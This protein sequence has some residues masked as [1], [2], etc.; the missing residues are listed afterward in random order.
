MLQVSAPIGAPVEI[1][2]KS[3]EGFFLLANRV[4]MMRHLFIFGSA[5]GDVAHGK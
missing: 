4:F 1:S 3:C 2:S 5:H